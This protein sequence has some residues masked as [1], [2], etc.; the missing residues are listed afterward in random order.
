MTH[1]AMSTHYEAPIEKVFAFATDFTRY[2]EWNASYVSVDEVIGPV[3]RVG[4]KVHAVLKIFGKQLP[5][6]GEIVEVEPPHLIRMRS[7]N[8]FGKNE[9]VYRFTPEGTGTKGEFEIDYELKS[10]IFGAITDKLFI[11][12]MIERD[13]RHSMESSKLFIEEKVLVPA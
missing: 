11:E 2:P 6:W 12:R 3:D 1:V 9:L 13:L 8:E 4:T 7:E 10:G 5:G